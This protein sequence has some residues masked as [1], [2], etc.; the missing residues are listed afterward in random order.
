LYLWNLNQKVWLLYKEEIQEEVSFE[1]KGFV[2]ILGII[3]KEEIKQGILDM[4]HYFENNAK[5][6]YSELKHSKP[7]TEQELKNLKDIIKT[8]VPLSLE[9]LLLT[10]NGGLLLRDNY[11]SISIDKILDAIDVNQINGYWKRNYIPFAADEENN[12]LCLEHENGII[13]I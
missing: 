4:T 13:K 1:G 2:E 10:N 5:D 9:V 8:S 12:F 6:I 11:K 7:A 3:S